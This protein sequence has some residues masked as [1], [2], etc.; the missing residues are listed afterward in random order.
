MK[1]LPPS[2]PLPRKRLWEACLKCTCPKLHW[3][4]STPETWESGRIF[5]RPQAWR[6]TGDGGSSSLSPGEPRVSRDRPRSP[7]RVLL[8]H[9]G[10]ANLL[11]S[12]ILPPEETHMAASD[13]RRPLRP[14]LASLQVPQKIGAISGEDFIYPRVGIAS[15]KTKAPFHSSIGLISLYITQHRR[16]GMNHL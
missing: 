1:I 16:Y 10:L 2:Q 14:A 15:H 13:T 11:G 7:S 3:R 4:V 8:R 6:G 12:A 9:G 5:L